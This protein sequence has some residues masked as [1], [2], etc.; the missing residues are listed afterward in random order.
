M[1][2]NIQKS[3]RR[4]RRRRHIR[5]RVNGTPQKP[6]LSIFRANRNINCQL[7]DDVSSTT[8]LSLSTVS[9]AVREQAGYGGNIAAAKLL[10]KAL[11]ELAQE[12]GITTAVVDRGGY[13]FHGRVKAFTEA[14]REAGLK[15]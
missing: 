3:K 15:L 8:I 6:R 14:A 2:K 1:D 13:K 7:V 11:A 10:G 12:K 4:L 5:K 9:P